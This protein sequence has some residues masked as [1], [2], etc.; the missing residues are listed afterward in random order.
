MVKI[1]QY[2][3]TYQS[4]QLFWSKLEEGGNEDLIVFTIVVPLKLELDTL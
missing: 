2:C 1:D 4:V 3:S